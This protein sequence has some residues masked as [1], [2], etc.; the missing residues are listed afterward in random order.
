MLHRVD[1]R[2]AAEAPG[3]VSVKEPGTELVTICSRSSW[4]CFVEAM[5]VTGAGAVVVVAFVGTLSSAFVAPT[6][7]SVSCCIV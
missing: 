6:V 2:V 3:S 4:L 1:L 5:K 7:T